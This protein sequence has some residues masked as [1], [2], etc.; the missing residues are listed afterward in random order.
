MDTDKWDKEYCWAIGL[1]LRRGAI[2]HNERTGSEVT[3]IPH[4]WVK[5]DA[6]R[7]PLLTVRRMF[8]VT[9]AAELTWMLMGKRNTQWLSKYTKIWEAF[10][11]PKGWVENSYGYRYCEH[12]RR[13]QF[14]GCVNLL[15]MDPS[16]RQA[17]IMAWD[18]GKDGLDNAGKDTNVPCPLGC[19]F[20]IIDGH[21]NCHVY[22]RS[23]DMVLGLPY[24]M[25]M[26]TLL[27]RAMAV[28]LYVHP[29]IVT[30]SISDAHIYAKDKGIAQ[31]MLDRLSTS[32][33]VGTNIGMWS[34]EDIISL[35]D[36]F[37]IWFKKEMK[38]YTDMDIGYSPRARPIVS[39][40]DMEETDNG[41]QKERGH[42]GQEG[43]D[44]AV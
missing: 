10:E 15:K 30:I 2:E 39:K 16:T 31:E 11:R 1:I 41:E 32:K 19:S 25:L 6:H 40:K 5:H 21:L 29:G 3:R 34:M 26:Y 24:D 14:M 9:A 37:M 36:L 33:E 22:H 28:T 20:T 44:R 18:P 38:S 42:E 8:P 12:F 7:L 27:T 23:C 35:P 4:L 13:D 43:K 17:V